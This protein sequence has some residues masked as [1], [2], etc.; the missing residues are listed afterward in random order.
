VEIKVNTIL[1]PNDGIRT[2]DNIMLQGVERRMDFEVWNGV[3]YDAI[4]GMKLLAQMDIKVGCH[5][6]LM[7]RNLPNGSPFCLAG[8]RPLPSTPLLSNTQV[9]KGL[10]KGN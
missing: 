9:K 1:L 3:C 10:R 7:S 6:R 4:I 5:N 8:M 2:T